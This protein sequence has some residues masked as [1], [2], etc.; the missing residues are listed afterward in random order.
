MGKQKIAKDNIYD[1]ATTIYDNN[2]SNYEQPTETSSHIY[3]KT[4]SNKTGR[5][6]ST[7]SDDDVSTQ[8]KLNKT[9]IF[10]LIKNRKFILVSVSILIAVVIV[11]FLVIF[12][13]VFLTGKYV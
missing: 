10:K 4:H 13:S 9:R 11:I 6:K 1:K 5:F 8:K 12:L 2:Y 3:E 7:Y